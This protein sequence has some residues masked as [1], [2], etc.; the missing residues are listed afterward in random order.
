MTGRPSERGRNDEVRLAAQERG[1]LQNVNDFCDSRNIGRFVNVGEH[2]DVYFVF[3]FFQDAQAFFQ[4]RA[5]KTADR[6][7][8]RFVVG[9]LEDE[10]HVQR[11]SDALDDFR[12]EKRV[13][14]ALN[15]AGASDKEQ[16]A[17]ADADVV[18]L[19]GRCQKQ[20]PRGHGGR[21]N[22]KFSS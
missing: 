2:G 7:A 18:D 22:N 9:R 1:D 4:A 12:H 20:L 11:A 14:L 15:D 19:E 6:G 3:Y 21:R 16:V 8:V 5:A 17:R 10:R 13:L